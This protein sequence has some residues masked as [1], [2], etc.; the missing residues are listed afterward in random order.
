[1]REVKK[2]AESVRFTSN[3]TRVLVQHIDEI[4]TDKDKRGEWLA[5]TIVETA[6]RLHWGQ[7]LRAG[8]VEL[9]KSIPT[10]RPKKQTR[11]SSR[12]E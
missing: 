12:E 10:H 9:L 4:V 7:I 6:R 8:I 5:D 2:A 1:M 11:Y 3:E